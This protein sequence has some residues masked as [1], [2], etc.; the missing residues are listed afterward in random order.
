MNFWLIVGVDPEILGWD[1]VSYKD[2][3]SS[4]S[5]TFPVLSKYLV[6]PDVETLQFFQVCLL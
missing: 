5:P 6:S 3:Y 4:F 1:R 2:R